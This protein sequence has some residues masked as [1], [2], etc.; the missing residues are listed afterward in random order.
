MMHAWF[1]D[2][3]VRKHYSN[4]YLPSVNI[5]LKHNS[6]TSILCKWQ[7]FK[8]HREFKLVKEPLENLKIISFEQFGENINIMLE[9]YNINFKLWVNFKWNKCKMQSL[10]YN[11]LQR[12]IYA[13]L[14]HKKKIITISRSFQT[15]YSDNRLRHPL[16]FFKSIKVQDV[17]ALNLILNSSTPV[18]YITY[19]MH[20]FLISDHNEMIIHFL[21]DGIR[22]FILQK[23]KKSKRQPLNSILFEMENNIK[24]W[25]YPL[26]AQA[27]FDYINEW[28]NAKDFLL[29]CLE[30]ARRIHS[31]DCF[32]DANSSCGQLDILRCV[33]K[34]MKTFKNLNSDEKSKF[35]CR[36]GEHHI[37]TDH[38][39][40]DDDDSSTTD[41]MIDEQLAQRVVNSYRYLYNGTKGIKRTCDPLTNLEYEEIIACILTFSFL[42]FK[43]Y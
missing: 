16:C 9:Y 27:K 32:S 20:R 23:N 3:W 37:F 13:K 41:S 28:P 39:D 8:I 7:Y 10:D 30:I 14:N 17:N 15:V 25:K 4:E 38:D 29:F 34:F 24:S 26:M 11:L 40:D 2:E 21:H 12:P 42:S 19:F 6:M 33:V 1:I 5:H 22:T 35:L 36:D 18:F 43:N 31:D